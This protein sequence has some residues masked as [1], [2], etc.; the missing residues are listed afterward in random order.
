MN[1]IF[2]E[3]ISYKWCRSGQSLTW[4]SITVSV[5]RKRGNHKTFSHRQLVFV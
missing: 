3:K 5:W 2:N 1:D 4:N